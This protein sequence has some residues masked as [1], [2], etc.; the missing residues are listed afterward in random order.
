MDNSPKSFVEA[1]KRKLTKEIICTWNSI[2]QNIAP[3]LREAH[4]VQSQAKLFK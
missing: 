1:A 4:Q 3:P 2:F